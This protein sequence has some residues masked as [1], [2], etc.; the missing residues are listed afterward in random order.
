MGKRN[1]SRA[2]Q[3]RIDMAA[4]TRF[5]EALRAGASAK[6]AARLA[7]FSAEA[8]YGARKRDPLF[9]M[10]WLWAMELSTEDARQARR[11]SSLVAL[12]DGVE[13]VPN[14]QRALQ[15][16]VVRATRFNT[17]RRQFFID[18]FA[19]TADFGAAC[20]AAGVAQSTVYKTLA[21]EPDFARRRDEA[22]VL[23]VSRLEDEAVRRRLAAQ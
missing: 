13:I 21:R 18:I 5:L 23:A 19:A 3:R 14:N 16:R 22:R 17:A 15:K 7:G 9:G 2:P 12:A 8:F 20:E 10:A 4:K 1:E 11:K 6:A